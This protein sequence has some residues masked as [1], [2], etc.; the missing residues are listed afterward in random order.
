MGMCPVFSIFEQGH[1]GPNVEFFEKLARIR[2]LRMSTYD[3]NGLYSPEHSIQSDLFGSVSSMS[4]VAEGSMPGGEPS[5]ETESV[6]TH[7]DEDGTVT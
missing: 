2:S 3:S 5:S 7:V 1:G 6:Q 4:L